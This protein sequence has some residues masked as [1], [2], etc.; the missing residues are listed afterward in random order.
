[1][2]IKIFSLILILTIIG[3]Y[4]NTAYS[5]KS[6]PPPK[7]EFFRQ[8]MLDKLKLTDEQK[9]KIED[10]RLSHQ[11]QMVD[12]KANLEKKLLALKELRVK[13]NLNRNDV[14]AAV[15]DIN[16]ARNDIAI[17]RANNMMDMY[18]ILTPEQ[19]KI[20][21]DNMGSFN[22]FRGHEMGRMWGAR[23]QDGNKFGPM[24]KKMQ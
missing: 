24:H 10:A 5:Q 23:D 20:W 11:K 19:R 16:Q 1:M 3:L 21:K 22:R 14:I 15:K 9:A 18:E 13:G 4:S 2:K 6:T 8:H 12:L 7:K 17:A